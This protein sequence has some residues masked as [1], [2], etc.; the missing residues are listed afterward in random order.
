MSVAH[1]H[2]W[3][4][5]ILDAIPAI[6]KEAKA[7]ARAEGLGRHA[8][9]YGLYQGSSS[10]PGRL[11]DY[12]LDA[13][14][15]ANRKEVLPARHIADEIREL[16]KHVYGD[17][18][19]VCVTNT[20]EAGLR[21][22]YETLMAPPSM[23]KG[24]QYRA[25]VLQI[26]GEDF[27]WGAGYGRA[28]PPR[29]K[30]LAID[31]TVTGGE[32]GIDGKSL[33]N[34]DTLFVRAPGVRYEIHGCKPN[35]VPLMAD[36]DVDATLARL[37]RTAERHAGTLTGV[38]AVGYDT[39]G[40]G[41]GERD[42]DGHPR[43]MKGMAALASDHDVP[44]VID[45]ATCLPFVGLD[46]R[47]IGADVM[48]YSMDKAGRAPISGLI[49]GRAEPL[50]AIRKSM[51]WDGPRTGGVSSYSKGVFSM[52]DPG[53]DSLVGL[54]AFLKT[55]VDDPK[56][57]TDPVDGMHAILMEELA[58][59]KPRRFANQ[60]VVTKS[61]HM[62][63]LELNYAGTWHGGNDGSGF[64]LPLFNLEDLYADTNAIDR[65]LV[66]MGQAPST[67]YGG[68]VLIGPG[69][70]LIDRQGDLLPEVARAAFRGLIKAFEI[71][72]RHAG[73]ED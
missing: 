40:W 28:F 26:L 13:I 66:A 20:A 57:V 24:D 16:V 41:F 68:N 33:N 29:Y 65:A 62:G 3:Y 61:H 47:R 14:V 10:T 60:L 70:G 55:L 36:L 2:Q 30:N 44:F 6:E 1:R 34:L 32:L 48:I 52:H 39:P 59:F 12:V 37:S 42:A 69:L 7:V 35:L 73:L 38:H 22:A 25:R 5:H 18:Y 53:R 19:D 50:S 15:R 21:V 67:I 54:H 31:R 17:E 4:Q 63:G 27:E 64:G 58:S 43:L 45:A 51:G 72:A 56:K 49:I 9:R 8:G 11:P 71:V 23:R 46:P